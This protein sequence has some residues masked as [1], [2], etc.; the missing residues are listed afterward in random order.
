[1]VPF[2]PGN[3]VLGGLKGHNFQKILKRQITKYPT[4]T[5]SDLQETFQEL[6]SLSDNFKKILFQICR[7][8][9]ILILFCTM[10]H[11][12]EPNFWQIPRI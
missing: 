2:P 6:S 9:Q 5:A 8:I 1:M 10:G 3:R 11:Y 7:V 4:I 12:G